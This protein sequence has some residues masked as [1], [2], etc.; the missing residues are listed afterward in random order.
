MSDIKR[1]TISSVLGSII[2]I[3]LAFVLIFNPNGVLN[4]FVYI[5]ACVF[6]LYGI[7]NI[8]GYIKM[9][10]DYR[11]YNTGLLS[12]ILLIILSIYAFSNPSN[13][14]NIL[15][16]LIGLWIIIAGV[17]RLLMLFRL[18]NLIPGS[19][20]LGMISLLKIMVG[21]FIFVHPGITSE[22]LVVTCGIMLLI[23]EI[24]DILE[25]IYIFITKKR[26]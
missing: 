24:V 11:V 3:L 25:S 16:I 17:S 7:Y 10:K 2:A 15:Y 5:A 1:V 19:L 22:S 6:L 14:V 26:A 13:I 9:N 21:I 20:T 12:G 18:Q 4:T 23:N 8:Y